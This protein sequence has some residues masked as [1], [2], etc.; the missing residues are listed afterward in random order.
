[1][2]RPTAPNPQPVVR[3]LP[4]RS[5]ERLG[6]LT[7]ARHPLAISAA[8]V[9]LLFLAVEQESPRIGFGTR[10]IEVEFVNFGKSLPHMLDARSTSKDA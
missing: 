9:V 3:D 1:M 8:N 4:F 5:K 10:D 2:V 6:R 7:R